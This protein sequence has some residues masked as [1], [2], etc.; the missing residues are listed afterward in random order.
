MNEKVAYAEETI[1]AYGWSSMFCE[2]HSDREYGDVTVTICTC[3]ISTQEM[4]V[5]DAVVLTGGGMTNCCNVDMFPS[6][7]DA[8]AYHLGKLVT[9]GECRIVSN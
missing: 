9:E 3:T 5:F 7:D 8:I 6:I 2:Y 4:A 1:R